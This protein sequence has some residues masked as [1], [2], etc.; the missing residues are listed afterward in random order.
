MI[1]A[2]L[3]AVCVPTPNLPTPTIQVD[4]D[5]VNTA[6]YRVYAQRVGDVSWT[7][8]ADI[9]YVPPATGDGAH[10]ESAPLV[11][12]PWPVQRV[13]PASVQLEEIRFTVVAV[14]PYGVES[15]PSNTTT[16][17]M[18]QLQVLH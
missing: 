17:C 3:L 13:L 7:W 11:L 2:L 16:I 18:P 9:D 10:G 12:Q 15:A 5:R 6:L 14:S 4:H 8:H 1:A